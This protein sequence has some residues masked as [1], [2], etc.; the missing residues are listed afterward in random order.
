MHLRQTSSLH[1]KRQYHEEVTALAY[2]NFLFGKRILETEPVICKTRMD[3]EYELHR[4]NHHDYDPKNIR[5]LDTYQKYIGGERRAAGI[6]IRLRYIAA[7]E[8]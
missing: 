4:K 8:M 2:E 7:A 3:R 5:Q 6:S 1:V